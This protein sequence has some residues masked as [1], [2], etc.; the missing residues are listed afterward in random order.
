MGWQGLAVSLSLCLNVVGKEQMSIWTRLLLSFRPS[1]GF[2]TAKNT[3]STPTACCNQSNKNAFN[4]PTKITLLGT[5]ASIKYAAFYSWL[6]LAGQVLLLI[7]VN[8]P[9]TWHSQVSTA[10]G[11]LPL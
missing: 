1:K 3:F 5:F 7:L 2:G 10:V 8:A 9:D 11:V 4:L 6:P